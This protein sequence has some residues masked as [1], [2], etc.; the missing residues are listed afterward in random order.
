MEDPIP[1]ELIQ[2]MEALS[3]LHGKEKCRFAVEIAHAKQQT[4]NKMM[5]PMEEQNDTRQEV[6]LEPKRE[7]CDSPMEY[8][9]LTQVLAQLWVSDANK[10][11]ETF[12]VGK[13]DQTIENH[14]LRWTLEHLLHLQGKG[15][16]INLG[17]LKLTGIYIRSR[18]DLLFNIPKLMNLF[19]GA[20]VREDE[21]VMTWLIPFLAR[22]FQDMDQPKGLIVDS[23][24]VTDDNAR[25]LGKFLSCNVLVSI[26]VRSCLWN[27][28][29]LDHIT[30][31]L[32]ELLS[33]AKPSHLETFSI[34][35]GYNFPDRRET[36]TNEIFRILTQL[37]SLRT[38]RI[39]PIGY[40]VELMESIASSQLLS[41]PNSVL[42]TLELDFD[43]LEG[44]TDNEELFRLFCR[45]LVA[46][47]TLRSL[48]LSIGKGDYLYKADQSTWISILFGAISDPNFTIE[49]AT[50]NFDFYSEVDAGLMSWMNGSNATAAT[51]GAASTTSRE[52]RHY[53]YSKLRRLHI[54]CQGD[55][56]YTHPT[57]MNALCT[58]A[59][60]FCPYLCHIEG[61]VDNG[62]EGSIML[63]VWLDRNLAGRALLEVDSAVPLGLWPI[64]LA[65]AAMQ[66]TKK[67]LQDG[68]YY[69]LQ[70]LV[71]VR[72]NSSPSMTC[73]LHGITISGKNK[74]K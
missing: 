28:Y 13:V 44:T 16:L 70:H 40:R 57:T 2:Q 33:H 62:T 8:E 20:H 59:S 45:S 39:G 49:N 31:G 30:T 10:E 12:H 25:M 56:Y 24:T 41:T 53:R 26:E 71:S 35:R 27:G 1:D 54:L 73:H 9:R 66:R 63:P 50:L 67:P 60:Q 23:S 38:V 51:G 43:A 37:P 32:R 61:I 72:V 46:N 69:I 7:F 3:S 18:F 17:W 58:L 14:A 52:G 29:F 47:N 19:M 4:R 22:H 48:Q 15:V 6:V 74:R 42:R 11:M 34:F 36:N 65:K 68:T 21:Y 55:D 64:V 5:I